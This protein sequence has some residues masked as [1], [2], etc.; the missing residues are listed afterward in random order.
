MPANR[1]LIVSVQDMSLTRN[2]V[3]ITVS[4]FS[5]RYPSLYMHLFFSDEGKGKTKNLVEF[6]TFMLPNKYFPS[7]LY[8]HP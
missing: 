2:S 7:S 6:I 8:Y 1:L 5:C 4:T 3:S